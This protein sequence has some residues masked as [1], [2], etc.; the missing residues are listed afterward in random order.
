MKLGLVGHC[1]PIRY[2]TALFCFTTTTLLIHPSKSFWGTTNTR[3]ERRALPFIGTVAPTYSSTTAYN[4]LSFFSLR[5]MSS[6]NQNM[7][8]ETT[9]EK[10]SSNNNNNNKKMMVIDPFCY[11]QFAEHPSSHS[12]SGTV[13]D[14]SMKQLE[15]IVNER[16]YIARQNEDEENETSSIFV[17]GYAPFCQHFFIPTQECFVPSSSSLSNDPTTMPNIP[18]VNVLSIT[19]NNE[20]LLRTKYEARNE[21]ELPVLVRYF[22]KELILSQNVQ[23]PT[24]SYLDII[25]YSREQIQ[26]ENKAQGQESIPDQNDIPWGII[27]IKAQDVNYELP[28]NPI[29]M[30]RNALGV[31]EGGSG[32]SLSHT[33]YMESVHYW[34]DRAIIS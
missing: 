4:Y 24:A 3:Y 29:T 7:D 25:L 22:P 15:E 23:L 17:E 21:K 30:M 18:T 34:Q 5:T 6:T 28:M 16:Y 19:A 26:K 13:F 8:T 31:T 2:S 1:T 14:I 11:R 20:H 32:I 9:M 33:A 12:Y 10:I 27:S